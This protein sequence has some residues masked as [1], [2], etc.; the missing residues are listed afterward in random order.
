LP[1]GAAPRHSAAP[2]LGCNRPPRIESSVLLPQPEGPTIATTSPA[3][4]VNET[5]SS[6]SSVPKRWLIWSAIRSIQ[7]PA[8]IARRQR[9]R[10][11]RGPLP[12]SAP[13]RLRLLRKLRRA[14][15]PPK[16][17]ERRRKQSSFLVAATE[18]GLLRF[19]RNDG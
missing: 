10:A 8:A 6:T 17:G 1:G 18:A 9:V 5:S 11:K 13:T 19:A 16:L 2:A 3:P 7:L 12:G 14:G 4:T 15:S